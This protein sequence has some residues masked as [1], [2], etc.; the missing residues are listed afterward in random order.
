MCLHLLSSAEKA[1]YVRV[2]KEPECI[3][4]GIWVPVCVWVPAR[5]PQELNIARQETLRIMELRQ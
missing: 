2:P 4:Q 1:E 5:G 3:A